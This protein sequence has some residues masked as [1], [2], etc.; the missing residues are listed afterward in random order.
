MLAYELNPKDIAAKSSAAYLLSVRGRLFESL[1]LE[2]SAMTHDDYSRYADVQIALVLDLV[3]HPAAAAWWARAKA[4]NP[5]QVVVL[6]EAAQSQLRDGM[7]IAALDVLSE[8]AGAELNSPRLLLLRGRAAL[9]QGNFVSARADFVAAGDRAAAALAALSALESDQSAAQ[10]QIDSLQASM[11]NGNSWPG[12]RVELAEIY[13][14]TGDN[15]KAISLVSQAV[16]L[17]WRDIGTLEHS[18]FL[19]RVIASREWPLVRSRIE[20]ELAIQR[21][22]IETAPELVQ[23]LGEAAEI[24]G[25]KEQKLEID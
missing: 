20:Q 7:A 22:L 12:T 8:A 24:P 16:D 11:L 14:A 2:T 18:P 25:A 5:N 15:G 13:A 3:D 19:R 4:L 21:E 9:L 6:A 17:G 1:S 23:I 10:A